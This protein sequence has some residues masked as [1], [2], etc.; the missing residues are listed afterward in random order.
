MYYLV[1]AL[2][3]ILNAACLFLVA[4][5]LPG[6][7]LMA[8]LTGLVAWV[9]WRPEHPIGRWV[10]IVILALAAVGEILEFLAGA[11]GTKVA[12]G[13]RGG[14]VGAL[15]GGIVGGIVGTILIPIPLVGTVV[16]ACLGAF[17]GAVIAEAHGGME[18][19]L[20]LRSGAGAGVGRLAGTVTKLALGVAIW[21]I[22]LVAVL[23]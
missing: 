10:L 3:P 23:V 4:L 6:N 19:K 2:L 1:L 12:G 8:L 9:Y 21:T 16:G 22:V 18:F 14:A 11:L 17:A 20:S 7:W 5:G 13:T 15:L